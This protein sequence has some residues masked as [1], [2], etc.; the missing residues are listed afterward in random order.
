[1]GWSETPQA[2][3]DLID[4]LGGVSIGSVDVV[5]YLGVDDD[6]SFQVNLHA[7]LGEGFK[8]LGWIL[9]G[10]ENGSRRRQCSRNFGAGI[11]R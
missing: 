1:M 6:F 9:R 2:V 7:F 3:D 4:T 8:F 11:D 5:L 10:G